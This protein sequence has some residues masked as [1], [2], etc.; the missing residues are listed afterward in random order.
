VRGLYA[1]KDTFVTTALDAGVKI[2]WLEQ[3]TGVDYLT[4]R[5]HYGKWMPSD[6]GSELRRFAA[7]DSALFASGS[8]P[9]VPG[10]TGD[11]GQRRKSLAISG[12]ERCERGDLNPK[13]L[14]KILRV[15]ASP[16]AKNPHLPPRSV[17][18]G[19]I[20]VGAVADQKS[21]GWSRGG[22][23]LFG[24]GTTH[25]KREHPSMVAKRLWSF[26]KVR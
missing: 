22:D 18:G 23:F 2:A 24:E 10:D 12:L 16:T 17:S 20:H 21:P 6:A 14:V 4:L 15:F 1:T 19:H 13:L 5:R 3:Q 25:R 9:V 26:A 11:R 7:L 8:P